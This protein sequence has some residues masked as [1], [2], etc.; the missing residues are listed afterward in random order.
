MLRFFRER[1]MPQRLTAQHKFAKAGI[2]A[3][4]LLAA[5]SPGF[6][7]GQANPA[8]PAAAAAPVPSRTVRLRGILQSV[9]PDIVTLKTRAG[10]VVQIAMP[11]G[12]VVSEVFPLE[13]ADITAG[14]Y[15][16]VGGMPQADGSQLAF[17]VTVFPETARGVGEGHYPFDLVPQS[18]MTNATVAGVAAAPEG[19]RL[20]VRYKDGEKTI[21]VPPGAAIVS[22][23]PA[24]RSLLVPDASVSVTVRE[25]DG[26]L[27]AV[28]IGAGRNGFQVPN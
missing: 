13:L 16:G 17:L 18:T 25:V 12:L 22:F 23:R 21:I 11:A 3:A 20:Q 8:A 5:L 14:S 26:K 2:V 10:E 1:H 24:D 6:A 7:I 4:G 9:A 27:S 15:V 28:R 19:R